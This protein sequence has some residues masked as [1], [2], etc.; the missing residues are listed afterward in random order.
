MCSGNLDSSLD[1]SCPDG[2]QLRSDS[3]DTVYSAG[4][5]GGVGECCEDVPFCSEFDCIEGTLPIVD[6][7]TTRGD[8]EE[9]CCAESCQTWAIGADCPGG[10]ALISG[11]AATVGDDSSTCCEEIPFCSE[12]ECLGEALQIA[13]AAAT[14]GNTAHECC[15][16]SCQTWSADNSCSSGRLFISDAASTVGQDAATCCADS[17]TAWFA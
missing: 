9:A 13:D 2:Q 14:R 4:S 1:V 15:A 5:S 12:F 6:A 16:E 10:Q 11:A 17:C 3:A 8:T 7:A